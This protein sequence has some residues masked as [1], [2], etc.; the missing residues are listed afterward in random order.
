MNQRHG[1]TV[2]IKGIAKNSPLFENWMSGLNPR[3]AEM[4]YLFP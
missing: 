3:Q 4:R 1:K 2:G